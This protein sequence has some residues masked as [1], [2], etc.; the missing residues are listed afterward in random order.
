M[1]ISANI[2]AIGFYLLATAYQGKYLLYKSATPPRLKWLV[3]LG[4]IAAIAHG[5]SVFQT[6]YTGQHLDLG[7]FRVTSLIFWFITTISLVSLLRRRPTTILLSFL[8][9]FAALSIIGSSLSSPPHELSMKISSGLVVHILCSILAYSVLTIAAIQAAILS[10]QV[11]ELKQH[12]M[13]GI[14]KAMPPLQTMEQLL[15]E[16]IWIGVALLSV[17]LLSGLLFIDDIFAQHLTHKIVL[18]SI[19]WLIF[20]ALLWGRYKLGWRNLTAAKWTFG[21]FIFLMLSYF[22]SKVVLELIL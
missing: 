19:A 7:I 5:A 20:S 4:L 22:G 16:M 9:P 21:G 3:S 10:L 13:A 18:S 2:I 17:S 14:L 15:F 11:H 12:K 1:I 8:F 6:I